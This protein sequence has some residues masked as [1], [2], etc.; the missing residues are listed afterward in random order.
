MRSRRIRTVVLALAGSA[1]AAGVASGGTPV[2]VQSAPWSVLVTYDTGTDK[3]HCTGVLIDPSHVVT[4]AHCLYAAG[5]GPL[6]EANQLSVQ[7]GVSNPSS[8]AASD[9]EQDRAVASFRVHPGY[10]QATPSSPDDVAVL[11][12][13]S[14]LGLKTS[15][16][17][18]VALPAANAFYPDG[19]AARLAGYGSGT[20][21]TLQVTVEPQGACGKLTHSAPIEDDNAAA[22][23]ALPSVGAICPADSGAGLVT[24]GSNA[25]LIGVS[26]GSTSVCRLGDSVFVYVAAPEILRFLTGDDNPPTAP[27]RTQATSVNLRWKKPLRVGGT[28]TCSGGPWSVAARVTYSFVDTVSGNVLQTGA[29]ATYVAAPAS[30]GAKIF[31]EAAVKNTGGTL[32]AD[33][34]T[35]GPVLAAPG[36]KPAKPTPVTPAPAPAPPADPARTYLLQL[37]EHHAAKVETR[38]VDRRTLERLSPPTRADRRPT[39]FARAHGKF[40]YLSATRVCQPLAHLDPQASTIRNRSV[41]ALLVV[42]RTYGRLLG[43]QRGS[44]VECYAVRTTWKWLER[45]AS[46]S[47]GARA[48]ARAFLLDNRHQPAGYARTRSCTL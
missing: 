30:V 47:R 48:S 41:Q 28:L 34:V 6:A 24:V 3:S 26:V 9:A 15:A 39:G 40:V 29:R 20:L 38:C 1:L 45:D 43:L 8:P 13:D 42:A 19:A 32:V 10:D 31:C 2:E 25:A 16:V 37:T 23:C 27:R 14:P 12:L 21:Q 18:P 22:F 11:A 4:A 33:T 17:K 36:T 44:V 35:T 46:L 7:A 5:G